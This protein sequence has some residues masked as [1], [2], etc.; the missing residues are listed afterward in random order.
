[1]AARRRPVVEQQVTDV[2]RDAVPGPEAVSRV[3]RIA[4]EGRVAEPRLRRG[5]GKLKP[6]TLALAGRPDGHPLD[7]EAGRRAVGAGAADLEVERGLG[8]ARAAHYGCG[9]RRLGF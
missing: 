5:P 2:H 7:G 4:R 6:G 9:Q 1:R 8:G 3:A